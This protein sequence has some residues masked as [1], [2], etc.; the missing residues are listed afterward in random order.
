MKRLGLLAPPTWNA[1]TGNIVGGHQRVAVLDSLKGTKDYRLRVA[2][3]DLDDAKEREANL[4]LNNGLAQG[5]WDFEKLEDV[6]RT[7]GLDLDG[8]GFDTADVYRLFGD[9]PFGD[10]AP[11]E[12]EELAEKLREA[13]EKYEDTVSKSTK[14]DNDHFFI[15][16]VFKDEDDRFEFLN[17]LGLDD[18]RY[19]AG[20]EL[21][22]LFGVAQAE[23]EKSDS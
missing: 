10:R 23:S 16:V 4:L 9:S 3:V 15:V 11:G 8:T 1:R 21:R 14:R 22:R 19:Q 5:G 13:R 20:H 7:P 2:K 12:L 17:A 18:N 6:F